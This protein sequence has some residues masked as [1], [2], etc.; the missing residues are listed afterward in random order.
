MS[1]V[2]VHT[3]LQMQ[4]RLAA[5]G[6]IPQRHVDQHFVG[7]PIVTA[8]L[9]RIAQARIEAQPELK[10]VAIPTEVRID[11]WIGLIEHGRGVGH[12]RG[13]VQGRGVVHH[14]RPGALERGGGLDHIGI[15]R[16]AEVP[17]LQV[18]IN[19]D[20]ARRRH[21]EQPLIVIH[22]LRVGPGIHSRQ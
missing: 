4:H 8:D 20:L 19:D 2:E 11:V 16:A 14:G 9:E 3:V 10:R 5:V 1:V 18:A 7:R 21:N 17:V 6:V 13:D 12:A 15:D 22:A